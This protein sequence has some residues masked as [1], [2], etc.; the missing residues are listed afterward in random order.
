[1]FLNEQ[2]EARATMNIFDVVSLVES[3]RERENVVTGKRCC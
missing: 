2:E 1:V 3:E